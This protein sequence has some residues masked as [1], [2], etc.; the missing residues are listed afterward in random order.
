MISNDLTS[1]VGKTFEEFLPS[2]QVTSFYLSLHS[3]KIGIIFI[4][5]IYSSLI[6]FKIMLILLQIT[7][8]IINEIGWSK[9]EKNQSKVN[10]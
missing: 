4:I 3:N 6:Q 7:F 8:L 1:E 2:L 5:P 9:L 10:L